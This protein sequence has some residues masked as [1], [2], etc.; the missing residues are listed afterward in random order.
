MLVQCPEKPVKVLD[1]LGPRL[2]AVVS[3]HMG[4]ETTT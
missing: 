4:A 1:V 3:L 2:Q